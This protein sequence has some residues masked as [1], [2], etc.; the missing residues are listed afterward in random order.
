MEILKQILTALQQNAEW[1]CAIAITYFAYKQ[2]AITKLQIQQD[3]RMQRLELAHQL[4]TK[5][6]D[7]P[8]NKEEADEIVSWCSS[9]SSKFLFLLNEQDG[10]VFA[11]FFNFL[12]DIRLKYTN[13]VPFDKIAGAKQFMNYVQQ[14]DLVL[15][16]AKYGLTNMKK[17][18]KK[19]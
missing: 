5:C 11:N 10:M 7:F 6:T 18:N 8:Y 19:K 4:D 13:N 15:G 3:L 12:W 9:H 2:Y 17:T 16:N 1:L 14:I